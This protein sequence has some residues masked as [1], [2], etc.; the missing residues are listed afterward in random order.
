MEGLARRQSG[1]DLSQ[2]SVVVQVADDFSNRLR[3]SSPHR[4]EK[5]PWPS[6]PEPI[7]AIVLDVMM[8]GMDGWRA[9][10]D[11]TDITQTSPYSGRLSV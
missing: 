3:R 2:R 9:R 6:R 10:D 4:G 7:D 1:R 11:L 8:P 5:R